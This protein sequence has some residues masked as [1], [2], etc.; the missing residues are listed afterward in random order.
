MS[1][2]SRGPVAPLLKKW[3]KVLN[4]LGDKLA[5][6]FDTEKEIDDY[7]NYMLEEIDRLNA[8][9]KTQGGHRLPY[10]SVFSFAN[11]EERLSEYLLDKGI[12]KKRD[13]KKDDEG[14]VLAGTDSEDDETGSVI[15]KDDVYTE[16]YRTKVRAFYFSSVTSEVVVQNLSTEKVIS[17][18]KY[19][20]RVKNA[21]T[22]TNLHQKC[23]KKK[24]LSAIA[25]AFCEAI[26]G[27]SR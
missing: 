16:F 24:D 23:L 1:D 10:T 21:F 25:K 13:G 27:A 2:I 6:Y 8:Y 3:S 11:K 22:L 15:F 12:S 14:N 7:L 20:M 17:F 5:K 4:E 19:V 18:H 9:W 26:E